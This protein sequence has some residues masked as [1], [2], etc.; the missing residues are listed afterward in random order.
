MKE[1]YPKNRESNGKGLNNEMELGLH[2]VTEVC[3]LGNAGVL[4]TPT[5]LRRAL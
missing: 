4:V 1:H 2:G 3:M 5:P